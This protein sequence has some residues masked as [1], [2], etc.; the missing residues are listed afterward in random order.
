MR[1]RLHRVSTH[2]H[3]APGGYEP[4][5]CLASCPGASSHVGGAPADG[6]ILNDTVQTRWSTGAVICVASQYSEGCFST[7]DLDL[8]A[9]VSTVAPD[10]RRSIAMIWRSS[11][12]RL[13]GMLVRHVQGRRN[14]RL[15]AQLR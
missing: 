11:S 3:G 15:S 1:E 2:D 4:V 5:R 9:L 8:N 13:A 6:R 10:R 7:W 14:D 12:V